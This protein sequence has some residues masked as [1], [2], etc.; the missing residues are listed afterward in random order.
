LQIVSGKKIYGVIA[1]IVTIGDST[2]KVP[3]PAG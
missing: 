3:A 2:A 1:D